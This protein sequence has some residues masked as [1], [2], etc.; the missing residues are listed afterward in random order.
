M[1]NE[2]REQFFIVQLQLL[3][4]T[5]R[6]LVNIGRDSKN[7]T[8][9]DN[10]RESRAIVVLI[11]YFA[12]LFLAI[13][14]GFQQSTYTFMEPM[15]LTLIEDITLIRENGILSEQTFGVSISA[16]FAAG[17]N[18]EEMFNID[19]AFDDAGNNSL[20]LLFQPNVSEISVPFTLFPDDLFEGT[21]GFSLAIASQE[22]D[23]P[24]FQL[25]AMS[26]MGTAFANTQVQIL[27]NDSEF[28]E[29]GLDCYIHSHHFSCCC[30]I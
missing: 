24:T 30:W 2:A 3:D 27:D 20:S 7:C 16:S 28:L 5:N 9:R 23:F 22:A 21:E 12:P 29:T 10:D 25:P 4:A 19:Y 17:V 6:N 1:V 15:E 11:L 14:I 13:Q 18:S 26:I 8:I